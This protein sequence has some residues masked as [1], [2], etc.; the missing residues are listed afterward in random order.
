MALAGAALYRASGE[1]AYLDDAKTLLGAVDVSYGFSPYYSVG[2]LA[3]ADLCG[4]LGR[5]AVTRADVRRAAC[6][7]LAEAADAGDV[8]REPDGLR[9][10]ERLL[11]RV[12]AGPHRERRGRRGGGTGRRRRGWAE[13]R[14]GRAR[15][16]HGAQS[17]GGRASS[18]GRRRARCTGPTTRCP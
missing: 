6:G 11:L 1:A 2:L 18:S 17:L 16:P 12:G 5:P 14:R 3:A 13:A 15:L 7:K 9:L 4:G 10:P 8:R